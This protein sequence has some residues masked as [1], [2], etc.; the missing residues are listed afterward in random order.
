M[1]QPCTRPTA[2]PRAVALQL[3]FPAQDT[4]NALDFG[5]L[6]WMVFLRSGSLAI[7]AAIIRWLLRQIVEIV[8]AGRWISRLWHVDSVLGVRGRDALE[9]CSPTTCTWLLSAKDPQLVCVTESNDPTPVALAVVEVG[10]RRALS[11][12]GSK[13]IERDN[14]TYSV[15]L[16]CASLLTGI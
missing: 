12:A 6:S 5:S 1:L 3:P 15:G 9:F 2:R 8:L 16:F 13:R 4:R 11:S 7:P 10:E 14:A